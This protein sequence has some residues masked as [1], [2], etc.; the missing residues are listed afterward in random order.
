MVR[1]AVAA[2]VV[3]S[4]ADVAVAVKR[5]DVARAV[6]VEAAVVLRP[7]PTSPTQ[8]PSPAWAH[9]KRPHSLRPEDRT[10]LHPTVCG[11]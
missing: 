5:V 8:V 4:S 1:D 2:R 11:G 3:A 10:C 7:V 9:R 6:V